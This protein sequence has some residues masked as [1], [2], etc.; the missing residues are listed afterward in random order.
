[1]WRRLMEER[2]EL[3][4]V[5]EEGDRA[6]LIAQKQTAHYALEAF[7][8][9]TQHAVILQR[10]FRTLK[11]RQIFREAH[12]LRIIEAHTRAESKVKDTLRVSTGSVVFQARVWRDCVD[13]KPELV[14]L[15]EDECVA[16]EKE[17]EQLTEACVEAHIG[18]ALASREFVDLTKRK[19]EFE[20]SRTRRKRATEGVKQRIQPFAVRAKQLTME[21]ARELNA[22]RQLQMELRRIRTE[23]NKFHTNLRG[24]LPMEP[25]LLSGDVE[26][27]LAG[28][29][30]QDMSD[31]EENG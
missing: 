31:D 9:E 14:A 16:M 20:R 11:N 2:Q 22:N 1:M 7:E 26:S 17:I 8:R 25:L 18:S 3:R 12:E 27:L 5:Q 19:N 4:R 29:T 28:L 13:R 24:R 6:T 10:W 30:G 15:E 23:L 21:S